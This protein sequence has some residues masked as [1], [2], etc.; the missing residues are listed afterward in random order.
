MLGF[1]GIALLVGGFLIV[2]TFQMLV[3]QRTRELG[4][5]RALGASKKQINRSV[6]FEALL[7][8]FFG[9]TFGLAAG[10]GLAFG[11]VALMNAAGMNLSATDMSFGLSTAFAGYAVG[12]I[13][14][15]LAAWIPARRAARI[16]PMAALRDAGQQ[17]DRRSSRK[18]NII[19]LTTTALGG[20]A[21]VAAAAAGSNGTGGMLLAL[22]V[23]VTLV[24]SIL[25]GPM[26]AGAVIRVLGAWLPRL[27]GPVGMMAQRNAL[28]NPRRT[29]ATAA[30]LMIGLALVAGMSVVGSSMVTSATAEMDKT[31]GADFIITTNGGLVVTPEVLAK[32]QSTPGLAHVTENKEVVGTVAGSSPNT[33]KLAFVAASP[34]LP[35]DF[36]V[37]TV[38]GSLQD[39]F[40]KDGIALPAKEA[41]N[42]GLR[43]GDQA[44]VQF[45]DGTST[46]LPIL[47]L[48]RDDTAFNQGLGYVSLATLAKSVPTDRTPQDLMLFAKAQKGQQDAAYQALKDGL[49]PFPQV[50][51]KSQTDYKQMIKDSVGNVLKMVYGLLGLAIVVAILGVI[52]TLALSVVERTREIGLI[53]AIGLGR[54][55]LRRMIRLESIVIA[56]FGA[57]LGVGLGLAWGVTAQKVM[58]GFGFGTLAVP[59]GTIVSVFVGAAVVGLLAALLPAFRASR[60]NVLRAIATDG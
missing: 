2:N 57:L 60:M 55:R 56:L 20:A 11:L 35:D 21:L 50:T 36:N 16:T 48:T 19:G 4:L 32:A 46:T 18:R 1:A 7:L 23:V 15:V 59:V 12:I 13:V 41:G 49:T 6:L 31:V 43:V 29:G 58:A 22:G 39:V 17:G 53:R 3:A 34:T 52:N 24:G 28:R 26:L 45:K 10:A 9:A 37:Q 54:R 25:I 14:T 51:V 30:A 5:L 47:A 42:R 44:T 38:A 8:G 27:F 33:A 40:K